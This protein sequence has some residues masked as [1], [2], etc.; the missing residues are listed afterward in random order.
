VR[1]WSLH[2]KYLDRIGLVA[3]W[4]EGL[5]AQKVLLGETKG[6]RLHPQL[7][8]FRSEADPVLAVGCYLDAVV[9]EAD[10]R[11]YAF[12]RSKIVRA[13]EPPRIAITAGQID[14]EWRHLLNKLK[15]RA[16][17]VFE[18]NRWLEM[19]DPHPLFAVVPGGIEGWERPARLSGPGK[20]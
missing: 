14:Y 20:E 1:L 15:V 18:K 10:R 5:L 9:E 11:G 6:Y 2:P 8:R 7:S 12:A 4:R 13:G 3:L 16:P 17:E 19:V